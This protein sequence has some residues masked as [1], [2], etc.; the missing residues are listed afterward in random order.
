M[1]VWLDSGP[2]GC[3]LFATDQT[4]RTEELSKFPYDEGDRIEIGLLNNMADSA[5]EQTE[6]QILKLLHAASSGMAV[7]LRLYALPSVL[8]EE[9]GRKHLSRMHYLNSADLW[10]SELDGL[11]ITG[12]E[13]RASDLK[14]EAYWHELT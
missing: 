3:R 1:P 8:R 13:P 12:A 6:R 5:L 14:Q 9:W 11:I 10:N 7:R 2:L 4:A